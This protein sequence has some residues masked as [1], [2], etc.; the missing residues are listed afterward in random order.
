[1][2]EL[3]AGLNDG[4]ILERQA[5]EKL[6]TK[7]RFLFTSDMGIEVLADILCNFCHFGYALENP[8]EVA[9][10]NVG[11]YIMGR[12]GIFEKGEEQDIVRALLNTIPLPK[13]ETD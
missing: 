11:V 10:Y 13:K 12:L 8:E 2:G 4:E 7:Y 9:Q 6:K 5:R 3:F 1:M